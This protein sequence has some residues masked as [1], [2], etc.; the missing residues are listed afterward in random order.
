MSNNP[1]R[2]A[3]AWAVR[4]YGRPSVA[5]PPGHNAACWL[6]VQFIDRRWWVI[7]TCPCHPGEP[8]AAP[9]ATE[10]EAVRCVHKLVSISER[11]GT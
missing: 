7:R 6:S 2:A 1:L 5:E 8:V 11:L 3:A 9:Y 10:A 4:R